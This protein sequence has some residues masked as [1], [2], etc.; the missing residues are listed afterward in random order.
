MR[1][2]KAM[3]TVILLYPKPLMML[4]LRKVRIMLE[5]GD[6]CTSGFANFN[7]KNGLDN[8]TVKLEG[9]MFNTFRA[10]GM[11]NLL[12]KK[13]RAKQ[14]SWYIASELPLYRQLF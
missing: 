12:N 5:K 1:M 3:P 10:L 13:Q 8:N 9:G 4:C 2:V 11:F 14:Q 6:F 7:T